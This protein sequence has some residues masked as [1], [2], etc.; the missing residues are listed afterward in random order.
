MSFSI[1]QQL[2]TPLEKSNYKKLSSY[3]E[4]AD[5][6]K[7]VS[8]NSSL[9]KIFTIGKTA[10]DRDIFACKISSS[11]FNK[12][13][14]KIKV[15]IFAQQHGNEHSGKEAALILLKNI[16]EKKLNYLF[17]KIDLLLIPQVNPDGAEKNKRRN[18][19]DV[20]LNRN[21]LI[22]TEPETIALHKLFD[23]YLPEATLDV[24]EYYPYTEEWKNFGYYK[25]YDVQV[26][27]I[28]NI[29]V[30]ERI[31]NFSKEVFL[32]YILDYLDSF[33]FSCHE[34]IVG[35]PPEKELIRHSTFDINDGRQSFG[36]QNTFSFIQEGINGKE[37]NTDNIKRRAESQAR[38]II[39]FLEFIYKNKDELKTMISIE[40]NKLRTNEL[41][42]SVSIQLKHINNNEVLKLKLLSVYSKQDTMIEVNNYHSTVSSHYDVVKPSGY[43]IS[44]QMFDVVNWLKRQNITF[45]S[46]IKNNEDTI[47]QYSISEIDSIDFEG[48]KIMS[49]ITKTNIVTTE[50]IDTN[51][52]FVPINQLKSNLIVMALEPKSMLG[53]ATY[54]EFS[55]LIKNDQSFPFL[56]VIR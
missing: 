1:A 41:K 3:S 55:Y 56:R 40:R 54:K 13:T 29:N 31:R 5:Y 50:V 32:P 19:N 7:I 11:E 21:H 17:D 46:F 16:C 25:N 27:S 45:S 33:N 49:P 37:Q 47:E 6:L 39:G 23:E 34:Y 24:H 8:E 48:D 9:I 14:S 22:L 15:M 12:D 10:E 4:M 53:L 2:E 30:S 51:Y 36:I 28:T 43:L 18:G 38:G 35:G 26:G 44:K 42:E 20:D 52:F